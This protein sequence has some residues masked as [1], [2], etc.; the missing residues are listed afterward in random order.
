MPSKTSG[1]TSEI[2][3]KKAAATDS[4]ASEGH[5]LN[6]SI[7][8]QFTRDGNCLSRARNTSPIGLNCPE[9]EKSKKSSC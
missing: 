3:L 8:Q 5:S 4:K 9:T 2:S 7:V 1:V 6:Q